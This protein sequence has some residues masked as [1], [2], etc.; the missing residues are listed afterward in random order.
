M[1]DI[2]HEPSKA[3]TTSAILEYPIDGIKQNIRILEI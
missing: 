2:L 3:V 1:I